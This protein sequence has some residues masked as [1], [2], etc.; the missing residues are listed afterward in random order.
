MNEFQHYWNVPHR[1]YSVMSDCLTSGDVS[2]VF[3]NFCKDVRRTLYYT[4]MSDSKPEKF[5]KRISTSSYRPQNDF[6]TSIER[7]Q[8]CSNVCLACVKISVDVG[9]TQKLNVYNFFKHARH[10]LANTLMW[11]RAIMPTE[12]SIVI[13]LNTRSKLCSK[14]LLV[15]R[16]GSRSLNALRTLVYAYRVF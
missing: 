10:T 7:V 12:L 2:R 11:D 8:F 1:L 16:T 14:I 9:H 6:A 13:V 3:W 5:D 15:R 4:L